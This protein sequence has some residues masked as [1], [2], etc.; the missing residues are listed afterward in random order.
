MTTPLPPSPAP[1]DARTSPRWLRPLSWALLAVAGV[2]VLGWAALWVGVGP[3]VPH[4]AS[5]AGVAIGGLSQPEAV[6]RLQK[7]LDTSG[8]TVTL[9]GTDKR[10]SAKHLGLTFEPAATV[11]AAGSRSVNPWQLLHQWLDHDVAPVLTVD[12]HRLDRTVKHLARGVDEMARQGGVTYDGLQVVTHLPRQG[13]A[14]DPKAAS[15][16]IVAGYPRTS[17]SVTLPVHDVVPQVTAE[18]VRAVA[19]GPALAAIAAPVQLQLAGVQATVSPEVIASALRFV[20]RDGQLVPV[21]DGA[22]IHDAVGD[23]LAPVERPA[24]DATFDVS[25]GRAVVVPARLGRGVTDEA[26]AQGV[27]SVLDKPEGERTVTLQLGPVKPELTTADARALGV[28]RVV[29]SFTQWFPYAAYRVTNI[30]LAAKKINGTLLKPGDTFSLNGIVGERTPENGFVK[31]Y[32]IGAGNELIEDY[33]GAVS[34]ITTATWHTAFYAGMTRLEQRAHGFWIDRYEPGLE[35]TVSWGSLDLRFRNDTPYGVY[36]TTSMTS[37][38]VTVTMWSTKYWDISAE[39]GP[40]EN[41]TPFSTVHSTS[42]TCVPQEGVEGFD[43]TVTRVW[44]RDGKVVKK[45]PLTTHYDPAPT[46]ICGPPPKPKPT[47]SPSPSGSPSGSPTPS[48]SPKPSGTHSP[49]P[50]PSS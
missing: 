47:K 2:V 10:V 38:T 50:S 45:E 13:V 24:K 12:E 29:S 32:V 1:G 43:I 40:K 22:T 34:T 23:V 18:Q 33:G 7:E 37:D 44:K 4:G 17:G 36:I 3:A 14:L 15:A 21:V 31:G 19:A 42:S 30:G 20:P 6:D 8:L 16:A 46:V 28:K 41:I 5:V 35:A 48:P 26:L 25:S 27:A 11:A 49:K 39:V 9:A